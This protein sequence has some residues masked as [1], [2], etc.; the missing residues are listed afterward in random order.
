[1]IQSYVTIKRRSWQ[2]G[3]GELGVRSEELGVEVL[4]KSLIWYTAPMLVVA[5]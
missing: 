1:M 3:F 5:R 4:S 2:E